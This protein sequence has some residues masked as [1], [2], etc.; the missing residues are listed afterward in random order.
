MAQSIN[1]N[2]LKSEI[3]SRKKEKNQ[4]SANVNGVATTMPARD[5]FLSGLLESFQTGRDTHSSVVVKEVVNKVAEKAGENAP[6][7]QQ[8]NLPIQNQQSQPHRI[9]NDDM[10]PER[11][12]QLFLDLQKRR[13]STLVESIQDLS[14]VP[15]IGAPMNNQVPSTP[16]QLNEA[17]LTES[18]KNIVNTYL[19]ENFGPIIEESI[20]SSILE[21]YAAERIKAV[22]AENKEMVRTMVTEVIKEISDRQK[23][24]KA[25]QAQS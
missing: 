18:V 23:A 9:T 3:D 22:L 12:E 11:D 16:M 10:S 24:R 21:M 7:R 8:A 13:N 19:V 15:M 2:M 17:Y 25:Q 20:K 4:V 5:A 14:K 6:I 1:L